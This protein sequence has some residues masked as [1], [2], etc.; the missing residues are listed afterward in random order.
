M[1]AN[2]QQNFN[3]PNAISISRILMIPVF[4]YMMMNH[5]S[6]GAF[7]VFLIASSTDFLDG[8]AARLLNQKTKLGALLD[9]A[10]DK[11]FMTSAFIILTLPSLNSPNMIPFWL[12]LGVIGRDVIIA[13]GS[14]YLYLR[15]GQKAFP[16]TLVGKASTVCQFTVLCVVLLLN[17][18]QS[19][20]PQLLWFY[21]LTLSLTLISGYQYVQIGRSWKSDYI[22]K[23][24]DSPAS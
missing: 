12:T 19:H 6:T 7:A 13:I 3:L 23:H 20:A 24:K 9:P 1:E 4:L 14:F 15:I 22:T 16:P 18:L 2:K 10:S 11:L 5:K 17:M 8:A 21:I